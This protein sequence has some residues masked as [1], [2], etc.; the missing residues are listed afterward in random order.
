MKMLLLSIL[1][2]PNIF[3]WKQNET[4]VKYLE[5]K[6]ELAYETEQEAL[7]AGFQLEQTIKD[8]TYN[9]KSYCM[10]FIRRENPIVVRLE[11]DENKLTRAKLEVKIRCLQ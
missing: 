3:A 1:L 11:T 7:D 4:F 5:L 10:T 2:S 6:T 9:L 8:G